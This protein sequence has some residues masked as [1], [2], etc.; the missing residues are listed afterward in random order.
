[1]GTGFTNDHAQRTDNLRAE[2]HRRA[3][4]GSTIFITCARDACANRG[5]RAEQNYPREF[6]DFTSAVVPP[7]TGLNSVSFRRIMCA[8][9][10]IDERQL[11]TANKAWLWF[12]S[13]RKGT[14]QMLRTS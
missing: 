1:M 10:H 3:I 5:S 4:I 13:S 14:Q 7:R 9:N 2:R 11:N 6:S 8:R 12:R